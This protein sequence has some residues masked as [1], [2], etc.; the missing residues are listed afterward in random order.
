MSDLLIRPKR[1]VYNGVA[2]RRDWA[3]RQRL[4]ICVYNRVISE[5][6]EIFHLVAQ[7]CDENSRVFTKRPSAEKFIQH[8]L[9]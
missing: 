4:K 1:G 2:E 8:H 5:I 6:S 7:R 3:Q 9:C